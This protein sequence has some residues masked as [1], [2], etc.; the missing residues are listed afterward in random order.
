M[1]GHDSRCWAVH[2]PQKGGVSLRLLYL[3]IEMGEQLKTVRT[4]LPTLLACAYVSVLLCSPGT[5]E[6]GCRR[7][8]GIPLIVGT[9][10]GVKRLADRM[11]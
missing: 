4:Y 10:A 3:W 6:H 9:P 11:K 8:S 1:H 2:T 5:V 7:N